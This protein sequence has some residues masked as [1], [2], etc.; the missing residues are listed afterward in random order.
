MVFQI[1]NLITN[2]QVPEFSFYIGHGKVRFGDQ[3]L[4]SHDA[5]PPEVRV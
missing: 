3:Q 2:P 1:I 5:V 4:N